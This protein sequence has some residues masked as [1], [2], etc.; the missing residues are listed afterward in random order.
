MRR[1]RVLRGRV[2]WEASEGAEDVYDSF[3]LGLYSIAWYIYRDFTVF[4]F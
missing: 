1:C 3:A 2:R 4:G